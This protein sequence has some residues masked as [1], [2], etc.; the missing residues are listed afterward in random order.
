MLGA[1]MIDT[2][3]A[4]MTGDTESTTARSIVFS[5]SRT[6]PGHSA[7]CSIASA[8]SSIFSIRRPVR[9]ACLRMK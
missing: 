1:L 6:L 8:G 7:C 2:A 9:C 3:R 5:S 4:V